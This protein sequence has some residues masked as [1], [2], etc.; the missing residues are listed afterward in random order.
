MR[1]TPSGRPFRPS[2]GEAGAALGGNAAVV[3]HAG[4]SFSLFGGVATMFLRER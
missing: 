2:I 3:D 4:E 1:T